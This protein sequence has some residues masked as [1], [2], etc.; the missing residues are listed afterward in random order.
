M[1]K[2]R[3]GI[4]GCG[5]IGSNLA[6]LVKDRFSKEI[7]IV[8]ICDTDTDRLAK[9]KKKLKEARA[10]SLKG[11]IAA[12]DLIVEAASAKVSFDIAEKCLESGKRVLIM[13]VGG[14][15]GKEKRLYDLAKRNRAGLYFPS[16][17]ICGL[18][19][20]RALTEAGI[21]S[22]TLVTKKPPKG[23]KGADYLVKN[24]INI[25][26]IKKDMV[27]FSG[28]AMEA[29]KAFPQ[30]INVVAV[31]SLAAKGDVVPTVKVVASPSSTRNVHLIEVK[32]DAAN[33]SISCQNVPSPDN[34]KTS[35]LAVLSALATIAGI[36]DPV[37][38]GN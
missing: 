3:V 21:K 6:R 26:G 34:P 7:D 32:S 30:N 19:G 1:K 5:A 20:I 14:V 13:S 17:A 11:L 12:S 18:D 15:L 24:N 27:V 4:V 37:K 9:L 28:T 33:I 8:A 23:L 31:L 10:V 38:I 29:V 25:E 16:G 2:I 36:L 35:Y 22:I